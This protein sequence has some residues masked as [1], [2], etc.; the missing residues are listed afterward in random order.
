MVF[1]I[2]YGFLS[3]LMKFVIGVNWP[4]HFLVISINTMMQVA[5]NILIWSSM[6]NFNAIEWLGNTLTNNKQCKQ[7]KHK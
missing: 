4:K 6:T 5:C 7:K 2:H 1:N 3:K